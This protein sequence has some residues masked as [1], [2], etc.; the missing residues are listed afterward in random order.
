[1]HSDTFAHTPA[2]SYAP[3]ADNGLGLTY[4]SLPARPL[5]LSYYGEINM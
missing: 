5:P 1:M 4:F 2:R 3:S